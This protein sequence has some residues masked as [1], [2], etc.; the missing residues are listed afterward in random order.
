M[1]NDN[2]EVKA[3][4]KVEMSIY[5]WRGVVVDDKNLEK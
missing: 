1:I 2:L 3:T 4:A 5:I